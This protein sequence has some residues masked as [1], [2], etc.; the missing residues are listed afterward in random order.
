MESNKCRDSKKT[1][2]TDSN[3]TEYKISFLI[4]SYFVSILNFAQITY[5][6]GTIF[7]I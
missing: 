5:L 3:L 6:L 2:R 1:D 4:D 7:V